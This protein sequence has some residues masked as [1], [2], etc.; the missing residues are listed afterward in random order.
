[1]PAP[2]RDLERT[3]GE[4]ARWLA[5][6]LPEAEGIR[7]SDL[8][9]PGNTG[10][11]NDTLLLD[12]AWRGRSGPEDD[13]LVVRVEPSGLRVFPFYDLAREFRIL[14]ILEGSDVPVPHARWMEQD[15][16]ILGAPFYVMERLEGRVP[17]D[18]PPYHIS[19]WV[20]EIAPEERARIWWSGLEVLARIHRIDWKRAGLGFLDA[21]QL[22]RDP[23]EG[24]LRYY[25]RYLEWAA[26]GRPHP[27]SDAALR[28]LVKHRPEEEPT[29]LCWGDARLGN[30]IFRDGRCVAVLD[31]EMAAL[32]SPEADLGWWL[33][34]DHHH[35]A[36]C[37]A[38]RLAGFPS[39]AESVARYEEWTGHRVR[40]LEYYEI[41]AAFRFSVIMM[42][43]AQQLEEHGLLPRGSDFET[44]NTC[45]RLLAAM[46]GFPAPA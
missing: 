39:R 30:M 40:H 44:N 35:S 34:F 26:R 6:K 2:Q 23:L 43:V 4:L 7:I 11:S 17:P 16:S 46:L 33:F 37:G 31:W 19:G 1:M 27:T 38:P 12:L 13:A 15:P 9:G 45:T 36:G 18:N 5:G 20:T 3:R 14:R 29:A 8:R 32:G 41:F 25:E 28:W 22:A 10:F 21:P 24:Q 42:R